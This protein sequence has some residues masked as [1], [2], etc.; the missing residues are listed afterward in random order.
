MNVLK[1]SRHV[2]H[3]LLSEFAN[4]SNCKLDGGLDRS[5]GATAVRVR[6]DSTR[7]QPV[8]R[9]NSARGRGKPRELPARNCEEWYPV[10]VQSRPSERDLRKLSH[11][12]DL[13][14]RELGMG[15]RGLDV[16]K[17]ETLIKRAMKLAHAN[18]Q[19]APEVRARGVQAGGLGPG[20]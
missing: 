14:C 8:A 10:L 5:T 17:R 6:H 2:D 1:Y 4:Q 12:F 11:A 3:R 18:D 9:K 15:I 13:A 19:R 16:Q 7:S 20:S